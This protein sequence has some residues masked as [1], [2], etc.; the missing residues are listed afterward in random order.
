MQTRS[1]RTLNF[2]GTDEVIYERSDYPRSKLDSMFKN[3]VCALLGYGTQGR[4]Q[5]LNARDQGL[6]VK[7]IK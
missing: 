3:D 7:R 2:G 4:G 6:K 1:M 5:A